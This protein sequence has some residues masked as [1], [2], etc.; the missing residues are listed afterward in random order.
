MANVVLPERMSDRR[1]SDLLDVNECILSVPGVPKGKTWEV[2]VS[3]EPCG[4]KT[5][6][7]RTGL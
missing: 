1:D 7:S 5:C 6:R 3:E 4:G 2:G